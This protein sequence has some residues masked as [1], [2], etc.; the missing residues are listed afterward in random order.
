MTLCWLTGTT[1]A[2]GDC[3]SFLTKMVWFSQQLSEND[4]NLCEI[5]KKLSENGENF[6]KMGKILWKWGNFCE[7]GTFFFQKIRIFEKN[8]VKIDKITPLSHLSTFHFRKKTFFHNKQ[9][10]STKKRVRT[11]I[12]F[13][14]PVLPQTH[15][16]KKPTLPL[17][18]KVIFQGQSCDQYTA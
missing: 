1:E 15:P 18:N 2:W 4:K 17:H 13:F 8:F 11:K 14:C 7:N 9:D 16:E 3:E 5:G 12:V 6:M 10:F